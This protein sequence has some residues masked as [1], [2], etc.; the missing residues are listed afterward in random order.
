MQ[1]LAHGGDVPPLRSE[2]RKNCSSLP[3]VK[4]LRA[5][6]ELLAWAIE[7]ADEDRSDAWY[8]RETD[9]GLRLMAGRLI[10]CEVRRSRLRISVIGPVSDDV[11]GALGGEIEDD[12][13]WIP[14][15]QVIG[16]PLDKAGAAYS[17]LKEAMD[18][19]IDGAMTRVRR[20]VG[21]EDHTAEGIYYLSAVLGRELPQPEPGFEAT[22]ADDTDSEDDDAGASGEPKVRGRAPIFEN[23]QRSINILDQRHRT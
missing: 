6:L 18:A 22:P 8:L 3:G 4:I 2:F 7:V 10:A 20:S 11:L 14:G 9:Q 13:K 12:F 17:L 16:M 23:G 5:V 15:G 1:I 19:F 21:L